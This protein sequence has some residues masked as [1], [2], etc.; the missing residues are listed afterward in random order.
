MSQKTAKNKRKTT[1]KKTTTKSKAPYEPTI[2]GDREQA[3][4]A[5]K[6]F[7]SAVEL[8][9]EKFGVSDVVMTCDSRFKEK[10]N[11]ADLVTTV[12]QFGSANRAPMLAGMAMGYYDQKLK[13]QIDR[14]IVAGRQA[15]SPAPPQR[16]QKHD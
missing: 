11:P 8:L 5:V 6:N 4:E 1:A 13:A 16:V 12:C 10:D 2:F 9:R 14:A 7:S 3:D 15:A